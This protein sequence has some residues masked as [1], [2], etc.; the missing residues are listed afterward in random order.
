MKVAINTCFGGFSLSN[1]A[2]LALEAVGK[3]PKGT[4]DE[5]RGKCW[6]NAHHVKLPRN[7]VDL[8]AVIE[9]LGKKAD[10]DRA[11]IRIVEIPDDVKF[12]IESYDGQEW[13]AEKHRTWHADE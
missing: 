3:V 2:T 1:A 9:R 7:D 6:D 8:V 12:T 4:V 11:K 5:G 13:V 10:G